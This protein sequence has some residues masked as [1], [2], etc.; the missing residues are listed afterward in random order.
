MNKIIRFRGKYFF[1][2]NFYPCKV[3][4]EGLV[5]PSV[6]NAFQAAKTAPFR[7]QQF[8]KISPKEAKKLGRKVPLFG[9]WEGR[10]VKVM[11]E[12]VMKKFQQNEDL[13]KKLLETGDAILIEGNTWGDEF[14]GV[15]LRKPDPTSP[16]GYKGENWL[17]KILM[18]VRE[19]LKNEV[20]K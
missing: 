5:Y 15:N 12:L 13:K 1:L 3:E 8:T 14:W 18:E 19:K 9:D 6:E 10:K 2:S 17:G 4:Y 16:W 11:K 20:E 7:R